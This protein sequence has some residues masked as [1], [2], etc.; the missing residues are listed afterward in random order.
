M[1]PLD[2]ATHATRYASAVVAGEIKASKWVKLACQIHLDDLER[3]ERWVFDSAWANYACEIGS[4]YKHEKGT[5]QGERIAF[6]DAQVFI[7]ASIFGWIDRETGVRKY[8]EAFILMPR[9]SGKSPLAAIVGVIMAFFAGE[10]GAEV[11][12]GANKLYQAMEVFRPAKA[13][14]DQEPAFRD[15]F[16]IETSSR[17]IYQL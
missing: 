15:R 12:C 7:I 14:I 3:A 11:Y 9:G 13:M 1:E 2:Y 10:P 17:A 16:G 6:E 5:K 4:K 8:R